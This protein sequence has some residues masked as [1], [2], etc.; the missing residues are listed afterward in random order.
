MNGLCINHS[1][2]WPFWPSPPT[3]QQPEAGVVPAKLAS[4]SFVTGGPLVF[5]LKRKKYKIKKDNCHFGRYVKIKVCISRFET[6]PIQTQKNVFRDGLCTCCPSVE[7]PL[8]G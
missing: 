6:L 2:P 1:V 4:N 7:T 3:L 5:L 8:A